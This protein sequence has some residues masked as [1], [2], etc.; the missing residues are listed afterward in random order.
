MMTMPTKIATLGQ[1][2]APVGASARLGGRMTTNDASKLLGVSRGRIVQLI[3][4]GV[5]RAEKPGR[6]WLINTKDIS[7]ARHRA[8]PGRPKL[9]QSAAQ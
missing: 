1:F 3:S 5:L 9:E 7:R 6:D 8:R 2:P 4:E